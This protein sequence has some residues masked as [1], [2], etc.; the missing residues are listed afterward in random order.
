MYLAQGHNMAEVGFEPP[1]SLSRVNTLTYRPQ[2]PP[3]GKCN[4]VQ[5]HYNTSYYNVDFDITRLQIKIFFWL[6]CK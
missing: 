4:T 1:T 6:H 3:L 5:S 2:G